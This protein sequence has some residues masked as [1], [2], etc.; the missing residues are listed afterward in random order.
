VAARFG[1]RSL[2]TRLDNTFI[3]CVL[4]EWMPG[5]ERLEPARP[6]GSVALT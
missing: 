5:V 6:T 3:E 4:L 1:H 2:S